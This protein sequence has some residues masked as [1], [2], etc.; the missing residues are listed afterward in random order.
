MIASKPEDSEDRQ[1]LYKKIGTSAVRLTA[2]QEQI[3]GLMREGMVNKEI[4]KEL[5]ISLGTVKQ[6]LVA[7]FKKLNVSNRTMAVSCVEKRI[8]NDKYV[9]HKH[10][11]AR[12]PCIVL[13]L[14]FLAE[15]AHQ[16]RFFYNLLSAAAFDFNAHFISR[17][18]NEGELVFGLKRSSEYDLRAALFVAG[19]IERLLK[20]EY[21][22]EVQLCGAMVAGFATVSQNRYGGWSG[23]AIASKVI[24]KAHQLLAESPQ[25]FLLFDQACL[26]IMRAFDI[27][28]DDDSSCQVSFKD[29]WS[30]NN[31]DAKSDTD[32]IGRREEIV[33]LNAFLSSDAGPNI[34]LMD[35]DSGMGKSRICREI[36]RYCLSSGCQ[37][38]FYNIMPIGIW[39]SVRC[40]LLKSVRCIDSMFLDA[41]N[42]NHR[43][44]IIFDDVHLLSEKE[45][46]AMLDCLTERR[47]SIRFL[48][49]GR[50]SVKNDFYNEGV[51]DYIRLSRLSKN[52]V[53]ELLRP[54]CFDSERRVLIALKSR[55]VPLFAIELSRVKKQE[56]SIALVVVVASRLDRF[57]L[58]WKLLYCLAG[59]NNPASVQVLSEVMHDNIES[60]NN[61]VDR[62]VNIG[63]LEIGDEGVFYRNT[64]VRDVVAYLFSAQL[65]LD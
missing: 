46:K 34:V 43:K 25:G 57:K 22:D 47:H 51:A 62:A 56:V 4:A 3:L 54:Y 23:D 27:N 49:S 53:S 24:S 64:L 33:R 55:G 18:H 41:A 42:D 61:A 35:G 50:Q 29:V 38:E 14:Q 59:K 13:S 8:D 52:Y 65:T 12:R 45:R 37:I 39:D 44:L 48:L 58:D 63:V 30:L 2:R 11:L 28:L 60:V 1:S 10:I 20:A 17:T 19:N 40:K 15:S 5:N 16:C 9:D 26:I 36:A 7:I 32:L 6:H 21:G 31:W